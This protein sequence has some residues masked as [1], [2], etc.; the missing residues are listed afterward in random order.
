M[1]IVS[2]AGAKPKFEEGYDQVALCAGTLMPSTPLRNVTPPM[3]LGNRFSVRLRDLLGAISDEASPGGVA[4]TRAAVRCST[5]EAGL[6]L[7]A[8]GNN[9]AWRSAVENALTPGVVGGAETAQQML[10]GMVS[11]LNFSSE[12]LLAGLAG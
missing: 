10:Q 3:T 7:K 8:L 4:Q 5:G 9:L 1:L 11:G 2:P 12:P 6:G